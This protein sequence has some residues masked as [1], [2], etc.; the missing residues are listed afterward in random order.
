MRWFQIGKKLSVLNQCFLINV[1]HRVIGQN[2]RVTGMTFVRIGN[3]ASDFCIRTLIIS[4]MVAFKC[5]PTERVSC[6]VDRALP[7][8]CTGNIDE[9]QISFFIA[10]FV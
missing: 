7:T 2:P 6:P 3:H 8:V 1:F 5:M 9:K 4:F 10:T